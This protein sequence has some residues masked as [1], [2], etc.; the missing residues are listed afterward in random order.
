[1]VCCSRLLRQHFIHFF[2]FCFSCFFF[3][4][5]LFL[6]S[7]W[8]LLF[9]L[10]QASS[11]PL[12]LSFFSNRCSCLVLFLASILPSFVPLQPSLTED[13]YTTVVSLLT[14]ELTVQLE[15]IITKTTFNQVGGWGPAQGDWLA[16]KACVKHS[17]IL[18]VQLAE[19][20]VVC[21]LTSSY[22]LFFLSFVFFS[23]EDFSLTRSFVHW[24]P[25]CQL[26][27]NGPFVISSHASLNL[28]RFSTWN[29]LVLCCVLLSV[30]L[31]FSCW[32][33]LTRRTLLERELPMLVLVFLR[34]CWYYQT[35]NKK[36]LFYLLPLF[37]LLFF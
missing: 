11:S 8:P 10:L 24:C 35:P 19:L 26:S 4:S 18:R 22:I 25:I 37:V 13:N 14:T 17:N 30:I 15:K 1:M 2:L 32:K 31:V 29:E 34:T 6:L 3:I 7:S 23:L 5:F 9:C 36:R 16:S 33:C 20:N 21:L 12:S 28:Q 27:R